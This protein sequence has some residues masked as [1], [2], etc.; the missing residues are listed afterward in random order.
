VPKKQKKTE[1]EIEQ[2]TKLNFEIDACDWCHQ[3]Y[4][5]GSG[6]RYYYLEVF[7]KPHK[8]CGDC[9]DHLQLQKKGD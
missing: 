2:E 9:Y 5:K 7:S 1:Y 3:D 4:P 6:E 8:L